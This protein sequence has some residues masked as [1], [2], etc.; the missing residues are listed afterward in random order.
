MYR[1]TSYQTPRTQ[2]ESSLCLLNWIEGMEGGGTFNFRMLKVIGPVV[3]TKPVNHS[4][5][6]DFN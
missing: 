4:P 3:F 5:L 2:D 1:E 6:H